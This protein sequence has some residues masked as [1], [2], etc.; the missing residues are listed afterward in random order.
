LQEDNH[1]L[2]YLTTLVT[3]LM[4]PSGPMNTTRMGN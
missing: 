4:E 2:V 3:L 1:T